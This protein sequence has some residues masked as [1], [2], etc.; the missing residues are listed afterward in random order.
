MTK[1]I[2]GLVARLRNFDS[3]HGE[4]PLA[5]RDLVAS[6][7]MDEAADYI[8]ST[9]SGV[10]DEAG[11]RE[12]LRQADNDAKGWETNR[13]GTTENGIRYVREDIALEALRR[14]SKTDEGRNA[15]SDEMVEAAWDVILSGKDWETCRKQTM[16]AAL[17]AANLCGRNAV[18]EECARVAEGVG[19]RWA[20]LGAPIE[21]GYDTVSAI[22]A[23]TTTGG[24]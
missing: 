10:V 18:I 9:R 14:V 2:E 21:Q 6:S 11:M 17:E 22:R 13:K 8:E 5:G 23:L 16:R 19:K 24:K 4:R 3:D 20:E 7:L 1:Q 15:V 12:V